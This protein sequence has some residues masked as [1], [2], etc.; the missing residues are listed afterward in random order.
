MEINHYILPQNTNNSFK[1]A[2]KMMKQ[3]SDKNI[4]K[5]KLNQVKHDIS[6][7]SVNAKVKNQRS[8][9]VGATTNTDAG[10]SCM[11]TTENALSEVNSIL[12]RMNKLAAQ[13]AK[14]TCTDKEREILQ[15]EIDQSIDDIDRIS[16]NTTFHGLKLFNGKIKEDAH[17]ETSIHTSTITTQTPVFVPTKIDLLGNKFY[18]YGSDKP[19]SDDEAIKHI[20]AGDD[21]YLNKAD[22]DKVEIRPNTVA[23]DLV[24]E[25]GIFSYVIIGNKK[26]TS[27]ELN[28]TNSNIHE[29]A[30]ICNFTFEDYRFGVKG[31]TLLVTAKNG[32]IPQ[33]VN[34]KWNK[35]QHNFMTF[36]GLADNPEDVFEIIPQ[37]KA[38]KGKDYIYTPART[39]IVTSTS[40][41]KKEV[42]EL[43][44]GK[45]FKQFHF[46]VSAEP[47]EFAIVKIDR[48]DAKVLGL[49]KVD[50]TNSNRALASTIVIEKAMKKIDKQRKYI[51]SVGKRLQHTATVLEDASEHV[52][53][54]LLIM[55]DKKGNEEKEELKNAT[56]NI[57]ASF[58]E[59]M[60]AQSNQVNERTLGLL[61]G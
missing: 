37:K 22:N 40:I 38:K 11:Q 23:V 34:I 29:L 50:L 58:D 56:S 30:T 31:T 14:G 39:D 47:A 3:S 24:D 21:L 49:H 48:M 51:G 10:I 9:L 55:E 15:K 18:L 12:E 44:E 4:I 61:I 26:I 8:G 42:V 28:L 17:T 46:Q 6:N 60:L 5:H 57:I 54:T 13:A 1:M 59:A 19:L 41:V 52:D 32:T 36:P 27:S 2:G 16:K 35:R 20:I 53:D 25:E 45:H 33:T 7:I 43:V